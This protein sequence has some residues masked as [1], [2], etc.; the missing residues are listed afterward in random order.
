MFGLLYVLRTHGVK[1]VLLFVLGLVAVVAAAQAFR[2]APLVAIAVIG[3]PLTV[4]ALWVAKEVARS[5]WITDG[6]L[7]IDERRRRWSQ[8]NEADR[9]HNFMHDPF[10]TAAEQAHLAETRERAKEL[11][12]GG[13]VT[14][15]VLEVML[16]EYLLMKETQERL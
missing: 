7:D 8:L 11:E 16:A 4:F 1:G 10:L 13:Q 5:W 9:L 2:V 14:N 3:L 12:P 15:R 6:N